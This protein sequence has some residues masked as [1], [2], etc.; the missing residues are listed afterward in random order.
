[1]PTYITLI[2]YT[3]KGIENMKESPSRLEAAKNIIK[4]S[5]GEMKA[6]YLTMG[7]YDA[8]SIIE[9]PDGATYS[10]GL[11]TIASKGAIQTETL[12]AFPEEEY[13]KIVADLP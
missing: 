3:Q 10:K 7:S 13:R 1:M 5:G 12:C 11:L 4:A 2:K 6:F 8:V 9:S